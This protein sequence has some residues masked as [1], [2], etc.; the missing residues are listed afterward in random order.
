MRNTQNM[1][2][3]HRELC[4]ICTEHRE[5][6]GHIRSI[7][8]HRTCEEH[9]QTHAEHA[10][11][12]GRT[13]RKLSY[14]L[15]VACSARVSSHALL[16]GHF[17]CSRMPVMLKSQL[18]APSHV[19]HGHVRILEKTTKSPRLFSL[20]IPEEQ[21]HKWGNLGKPNSAYWAR[22]AVQ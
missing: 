21:S 17:L 11:N 4:R 19:I 20:A 13:Y 16:L 7:V 3:T 8:E 18:T 22:E 9:A 6:V 1:C 12:I 14:L 15:S 10:H 5:H 2:R